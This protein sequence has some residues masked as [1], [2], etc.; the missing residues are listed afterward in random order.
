MPHL[1]KKHLS[2]LNLGIERINEM[3]ESHIKAHR[4]LKL[5][6]EKI[7]A[8]VK[9]ERWTVAAGRSL[10]YGTMKGNKEFVVEM[11]KSN[12]HLVREFQAEYKNIFQLSVQHRNSKIFNLIYGMDDRKKMMLSE[13]DIQSNTVLHVAGALSP[14]DE[15]SKVSGAALKMQREIQWYK[16]HMFF[17]FI[18]VCFIIVW[19][20]KF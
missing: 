5:V 12:P 6:C 1:V 4:F 11:I 18:N 10:I 20:T 3:K 14:S 15:L 2:F 7:S 19:K 8:M 13:K 17:F 9:D 16:V